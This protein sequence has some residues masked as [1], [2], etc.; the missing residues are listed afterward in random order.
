VW[1]HGSPDCTNSKDVPI[2][3]HRYDEDTFVLRQSKCSEPGTPIELGPS[4]EAPFMYLLFGEDRALLVDTGASWSASVFPIEETVRRLAAQWLTER[5]REMIPIIVCHSHSHGDHTAGDSQFSAST[6]YTVV[7]IGV[8]AVRQFFG[9]VNW[10][11]QIVAFELGGKTLDIIPIPGHEA[12][13]IALYDR[14]TQLLLTGDTLYPGLLV[15]NDW[16]EYRR[17]IDRLQSFV[18]SHPISL[19][20]GAHIEM[21]N[22]PGAWFGLGA[23]F[24]PGEHVLQLEGRHLDELNAA[25][26]AIGSRPRTDRHND[27]I[28]YPA[29]Q[30]LP[31]LEP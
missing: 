5:G 11:E 25:L 27:F 16:E 21:T 10:P 20:L 19:V 6:G 1:I 13:H 3:V 30:P 28:I 29:G 26:H 31:S 8:S 22:R 4:F 17:S 15:V 2:Q 12:A 14:N 9:V 23:L 24:Q 18:A 7:P